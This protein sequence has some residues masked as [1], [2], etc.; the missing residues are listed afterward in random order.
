MFTIK[1]KYILG[2]ITTIW[3]YL[4]YKSNHLYYSD[5]NYDGILLT[6]II[7][8]G[9]LI[10]CN[11]R[12]FVMTRKRLCENYYHAC[13]LIYKPY[14]KNNIVK[15]IFVKTTNSDNWYELDYILT[16]KQNSTIEEYREFIAKNQT[17]HELLKTMNFNA[18]H[19]TTKIQ[20]NL[21]K[22]DYKTIKWTTLTL[23]I[24]IYILYL[25]VYYN[26]FN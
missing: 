26:K 17:V 20:Y 19:K 24:V 14:V 21:M 2:Y 10:T 13:N 23:I 7:I 1:D 5:A 18:E 12:M 8:G 25:I 3:M 11:H 6:I 22:M 4:I 16:I 15:N 9:W